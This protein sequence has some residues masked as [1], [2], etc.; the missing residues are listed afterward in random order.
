MQLNSTQKLHCY[1][2]MT[3]MVTRTRH[4]VTL[5]IH[6]VSCLCELCFKG[7]NYAE[8]WITLVIGF[9]QLSLFISV[10]FKDTLN[11]QYCLSATL[12]IFFTCRI[13]PL[14]LWSSHSVTGPLCNPL[15][16]RYNYSYSDVDRVDVGLGNDGLQRRPCGLVVTAVSRLATGW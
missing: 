5:Y 13:Y 1:V 16:A 14:L 6:C 8:T 12:F 4:N 2:S 10:L 15:H 7:Y 3:G 9:V 11:W